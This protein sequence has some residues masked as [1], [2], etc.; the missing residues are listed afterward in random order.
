MAEETASGRFD[1]LGFDPA[2]LSVPAG[3]LAAGLVLTVAPLSTGAGR[4]LAITLFCIALWIGT[5][6]EPWF[7]A[8]LGIGLIGVV[9]SADLALTGF[10][11]PAT[12]LVVVGI[13]VGEA[14]SESGLAGL[15]ERV[16]VARLPERALGD[17]AERAG[18]VKRRVTQ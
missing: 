4:M 17:A 2:W 14:A 6:V 1:R 18:T 15:V 9:F 7:T 12:W 3:L 16:A 11:S 10:R 8:V 5:P 13:L